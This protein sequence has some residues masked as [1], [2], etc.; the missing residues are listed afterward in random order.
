[1]D[2]NKDIATQAQSARALNL[3]DLIQQDGFTFKKVASTNSGEYAG[4]CPWCGG[5]D[6]FIIWPAH[7][8][9]RY[10]CRGCNKTG[11]AIQYLRDSK[12]L[13][14]ADACQQLGI[15]KARYKRKKTKSMP[16]KP[17]FKP[18]ESIAP[19]VI[20]MQ[21]AALI[22]NDA[23]EKLLQASGQSTT[24]SMLARKGLFETTIQRAGLGF[25]PV[26]LY[27]DRRG[28]G[29]LQE[30]RSDG[31]PKLLWIPAGLVIPLAPTL[32]QEAQ[33]PNQS[34]VIRL[35]IR[36]NEPGD[37]PRYVIVSGSSMAPML[38]GADSKVLTIVESELDGLLIWQ[39]AFDLTGVVAMG[40]AAI[41]PDMATHVLLTKA[42]IILN[43]LD[44]DA[45]G[46]W[47]SYKFWPE[48][49]GAKVKRWPVPL[50]KDP[51]EAVELGLNIRAWI[52]AGLSD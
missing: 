38:W 34:G 9:G 13:S 15:K 43:A 50:G 36:R 48:T 42:E 19:P 22:L 16:E 26:D 2:V 32:N 21:K 37:G 17:I 10:Y 20:W 6:R 18:K 11:D 30:I 47:Q 1:M 45:A 52:E 31:K 4:G 23:Q 39:E 27:R 46:A 35:R 5:R 33:T 3:L 44:Y 25:N 8:G 24:R 28:W 12:G 49:Y 7:K 29:L 14:F 40:N 51:G 41:K